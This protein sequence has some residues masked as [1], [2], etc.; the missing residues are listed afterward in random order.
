MISRKSTGKHE[1]LVDAVKNSLKIYF[2]YGGFVLAMQWWLSPGNLLTSSPYGS[3]EKAYC[4]LLHGAVIAFDQLRRPQSWYCP[5]W[6]QL[7]QPLRPG[8]MLG[9]PEGTKSSAQG[10]EK[11]RVPRLCERTPSSSTTKRNSLSRGLRE[12]KKPP[13]ESWGKQ[14]QG[15]QI[16]GLS[17]PP[18]RTQWILKIR[19]PHMKPY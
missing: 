2:S 19:P 15:K 17:S 9:E 11:A 1:L 10:Q 13:E 12:K 5:Q 4:L 14:K 3:R 7:D 8:G 18:S 16:Q 6:R